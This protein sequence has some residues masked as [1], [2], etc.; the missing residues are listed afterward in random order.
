MAHDE[1]RLLIDALL[2]ENG[3]LR[4]TQHILKVYAL[5][6]AI[7]QAQ[8]LSAQEQR[9]VQAAA[10]LHD[11]AIGPSKAKYGDAEPQH[12]QQIAAPLV[13]QFLDRAGYGE[14]DRTRIVDLVET[15]H[16]YGEID[17][18]EFQALVEADLIANVYESED[19][20]AKAKE[21]QPLF[22]TATG[23]ALLSAII[24][25]VQSLQ[26]DDADDI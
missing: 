8:R 22:Q 21:V 15:L 24:S 9:I 26:D 20:C 19:A 25:H 10:I 3:H 5:T 6:K 12:Q 18:P 4:R 23:K 1:T 2:F 16:E 13:W 7:G 14:C 17:G 11:I